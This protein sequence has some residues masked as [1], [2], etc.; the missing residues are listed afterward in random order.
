MS[1]KGHVGES[2]VERRLYASCNP[3]RQG[4]RSYEF[5]SGD[6]MSSSITEM[7]DRR[8]LAAHDDSHAPFSAA[9]Q[10][11]QMVGFISGGGDGDGGSAPSPNLLNYQ[12]SFPF[13]HLL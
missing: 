11:K 3:T 1:S 12:V 13:I 4:P 6:S 2:A 10:A 5:Y 8:P 7:E 9:D